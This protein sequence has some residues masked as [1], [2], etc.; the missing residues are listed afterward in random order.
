MS[1]KFHFKCKTCGN[2]I[3]GFKQWFANNQKCTQCGDNK[4]DTIYST[5]KEKIKELISKDAKPESLW[6]Y[7]DFLPLE[8]K[9]NII[10][11]GEGV[12]PIERWSF[13]EDYAKRKYNLNLEVFINRND[14]SF[15][16]GTFKDKGGAVAASVLKEQGIKEYV[17]VSTGNTASAF[18]HYLAKAG[19]SCSVFVPEDS[20]PDSEAHIGTYGQ[21]L[22]RVKGDYAYAKKVAAEYAK[23]YGLLITGGNLDPLRLEAKKTQ[24]FEMMRVMGKTPDV[25]IQALSGGTGPFAV[26]KAYDDFAELNLFGKL[27]R[28]LLSQGDR[29]APMAAAWKK[30]KENNFSEGWEKD[31]PIY[32]NPKTLIP[33]IATGN[34]GMYPLMGPLVKK[35]GG[36]IFPVKEELA[37]PLAR[38]IGFERVIKIGPASAAGV[39]GFFEALKRGLIKDGESVF[40]NMGESA[41]RALGF[42]QEVAYTT[43]NIKTAEDAKRFN[44]EDYKKFVWEPF[45]KY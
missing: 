18:A 3:E 32:E 12:A 33:T 37:V 7:F 36:E 30:A 26:E 6:H 19:V 13:F 45:E 11:E 27:P 1:K 42:L 43:E 8:N 5:P 9:E 31:Y 38:L 24:V 25:Y 21:K 34:P 28:F 4:I 29:C 41:N 35:S 39:L 20:L 40:I 23:K 14:K 17:V 22:F 44:R 15:A 10:T 16:T 2:E